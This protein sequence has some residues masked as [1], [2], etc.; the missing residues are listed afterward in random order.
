LLGG[1]SRADLSVRAEADG[2]VASGGTPPRIH[3][4]RLHKSDEPV[5]DVT[6]L[7]PKAS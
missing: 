7:A 3:V 5:I 2:S 4:V 1:M 6:A